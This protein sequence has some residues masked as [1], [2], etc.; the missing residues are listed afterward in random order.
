M[1]W[2]SSLL[3]PLALRGKK[4]KKKNRGEKKK[5]YAL[6][7]PQHFVHAPAVP[8]QGL[9]CSML[10]FISLPVGGRS[11]RSADCIFVTKQFV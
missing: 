11:G 5:D 7:A 6:T 8:L 3:M 4:K 2:F 9:F 1:E 10:G